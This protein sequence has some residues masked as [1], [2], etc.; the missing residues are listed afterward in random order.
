MVMMTSKNVAVVAAVDGRVHLL[1]GL[2]L[3]GNSSLVS[4]LG[5]LLYK[6]LLPKV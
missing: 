1:D 2:A 3:I 5:H 4:N 6:H